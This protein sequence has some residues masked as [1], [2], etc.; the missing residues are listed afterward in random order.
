MSA[1]V[2]NNETVNCI[3]NGLIEHDLISE[4]DGVEVGQ[5]LF[6]ENQTS[7]NFRYRE[8]DAAPVFQF[9][10]KNYEPIE[11]YGCVKCWQYQTC[12]HDGHENT[13]IWKMSDELLNVFPASYRDLDYPWGLD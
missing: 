11:Y 6:D 9:K 12:E 5:L 13:D 2:V 4:N 7:V 3:V 8:K 1:Y 10:R